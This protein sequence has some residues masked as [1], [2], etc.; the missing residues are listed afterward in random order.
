MTFVA[1][2]GKLSGLVV[3]ADPVK[4]SAADAIAALHRE[5]IRI[6]CWPATIGALPMRSPGASGSVR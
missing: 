2:D 6:V 3:V 4:D 5:G 1:I